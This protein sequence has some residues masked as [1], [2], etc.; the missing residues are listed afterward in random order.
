MRSTRERKVWDVVRRPLIYRER[1][2]GTALIEMAIV[3]PLLAILC[4]GILEYGL[5]I[6]KTLAL[7]TSTRA[8]ARVGAQ[9]GNFVTADYDILQAVENSRGYMP[10]S[11][12]ESVVVYKSDVADGGVPVQCK[13]GISVKDVCNVYPSSA[14]TMSSDQLE[15]SEM[16][17]N[18]P[19]DTRIQ[20]ADYLG[21]WVIAEH[22]W[23]TKLFS[24]TPT[25]VADSAVMRIEP[26]VTP[27]WTPPGGVAGTT[28]T[29]IPSTTTT[30][31]PT[32][33]TTKKPTTT[34]TKS[35]TTVKPTTTTVKPTTTTTTKPAGTTT[36]S[37]T[38]KPADTTTTTK[39]PTTTTTKK[40]TTTTTKKPTTTT[41]TG[42][43][44]IFFGIPL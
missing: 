29:A 5:M 15:A 21:V 8:G 1:E 9:E 12:I 19:A 24:S 17:R 31:K 34:T 11:S 41:T 6:S 36:T 10:L 16:S 26:M 25:Q 39:K 30:K 44:G 43:G 38:K 40:P 13:N 20:G 4:F 14:F 33:T 27:P 28:T 7:S 35:T 37:T 3:A 42:D 23:V 2:S 22:D 32:T 18:W